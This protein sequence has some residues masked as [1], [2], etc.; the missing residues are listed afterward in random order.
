MGKPPLSHRSMAVPRFWSIA[1]CCWTRST[2]GN[3]GPGVPAD[4]ISRCVF[5]SSVS[6]QRVGR[7]QAQDTELSKN[8]LYS[9]KSTTNSIQGNIFQLDTKERP[10]NK[11]QTRTKPCGNQRVK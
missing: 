9:N 2:T 11:E 3:R 7:S 10:L 4:S 8:V 1:A 6:V 5:L